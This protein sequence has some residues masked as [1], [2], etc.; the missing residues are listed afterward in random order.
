MKNA[1]SLIAA[2]SPVLLISLGAL[3]SANA[4]E[5]E[6]ITAEVEVFEESSQ[7]ILDA[8][9]G[10][11][12]ESE[13]DEALVTDSSSGAKTAPLPDAT[14]PPL[15]VRARFNISHSSS[16]A[17][18]DGLTQFGGFTP[19]WQ[20]PGHD[21]V[22]LES[23]LLL[24]NGGQLGG[25]AV[26]GYR[27]YV[28][29][30]NRTLG[31][32]VSLDNR[33]TGQAAFNQMG[34]G[35]ETLGE[36]WDLRLNAYLPLGNSRQLVN[37]QVSTSTTIGDVSR[38]QGNSL[39]FDPVSQNQVTNTYQTALG[40]FDVEVGTR[41]LRFS[42]GGDLRGYISPY[43]LSGP[44]I[45]GTFGIRGRLSAQPSTGLDLGI[46]L[47]HDEV[48]GTNVFGSVRVNFPGTPGR[49]AASTEEQLVARLGSSVERASTIKVDVQNE[50]LV[51]QFVEGQP[52]LAVNPDTG[53]PWFFIH[54]ADN[55]NS[56]GTVESPFGAISDA[57][58]VAQSDGNQI[59]YVQVGNN[60]YLGNLTIPDNVRLLSIG[61]LQQIATTAL[62]QVTL[63]GSGT[64]ILPVVIGEL[65]PGSGAEVSGFIELISLGNVTFNGVVPASSEGFGSLQALLVSNGVSVNELE[66]FLG[67]APGELGT[68]GSGT[69]TQGS[70]LKIRFT[71]PVDD[72]LAF[73][74]N[75]LNNE[76][77][78]SFYNDFSFLAINGSSLQVLADTNFG[79]FSPSSTPGFGLETGFQNF[80][81]GS[82]Y[83]TGLV[84]SIGTV[85]LRDRAF[86]SGLIF[87]G[88]T[89]GFI[90][91]VPPV[92]PLEP[93]ESLF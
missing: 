43:Y 35:V 51:N 4:F 18:A 44:G 68:L 60:P 92:E 63:P 28:P 9:E 13:S 77:V 2:A 38:F 17:G 78:S 81:F 14:A 66:T 39:F 5:E 87:G 86:N 7:I 93:L 1:V 59:I 36:T 80:S 54:V 16:S 37:S 82:D 6:I 84:F 19:I 26:L 24:D 20:T 57:V 64:G 8:T 65:I 21:I 91:P 32:Y 62:G 27:Q 74:W 12:S 52:I 76:G 75:F 3:Q 85:D 41:L 53:A 42:N 25:N 58:A 10:T 71:A 23:G 61:P 30:Q 11:I 89:E 50:L 40:S 22:F 70:T 83:P 55:G 49:S 15:N 47:Q 56:D 69:V 29:G 67:V 79:T 45:S 34:F 31:G 33:N 73:A 88:S 90:P 72:S 46:G 48:F